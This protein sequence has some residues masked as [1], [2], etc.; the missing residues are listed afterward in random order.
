[1]TSFSN[2]IFR[3]AEDGTDQRFADLNLYRH[4]PGDLAAWAERE[5]IEAGHFHW[6]DNCWLK[7]SVG[8]D[9]VARYLDAFVDPEQAARLKSGLEPHVRSS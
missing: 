7:L 1:M 8:P 9:H 2:F 6:V 5:G 3:L 4:G